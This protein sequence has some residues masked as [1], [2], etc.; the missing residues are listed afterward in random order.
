MGPEADAESPRQVRRLIVVVAVGIFVTGF[1]WPGIIGRLPFTLLLKNQ[2]GLGADKVAAFWAVATFAWYCK[3]LVGLVCDAYPF[4]GTRR[5]GYMLWGA[6]LAS[7]CWLGFAFVPRRYVPFMALMTGLNLALVFV[8]TVVGG[9]QV[10]ASQRLGATGRFASMRSALEGTMYLLSGPI[11]GFLAVLA[12]GWTSLAGGLILFS[13]VPVVARL[14]PEA[15][16]ARAQAA[17]W[18]SAR[19][20]LA[21]IVRSRPMWGT[22]GLTFLYYLAPGFQTPLL[23]V[24]QDVLKLDPRMMGLLVALSGVGWMIGSAIYAALCRRL[25]LRTLLVAGIAINGLGTLLYLRYD[26]ALAAVVIETV[27]GV[28]YTLAALP[29]ADLIARATPKGSESFGF[30]LMMSIRNVA[31]FAISD[32]VGSKLY[33]QYHV[34]FPRLVWINTLST[35]AVLLFVP[36]LPR[37]ILAAREG[38]P[39]RPSGTEPNSQ[40]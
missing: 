9:L 21:A 40:A 6:L 14:Y 26:S 34:G 35:L 33:A 15:R 17:V 27:F 28:L 10:E 4:A 3:P 23:Y 20:Q 18:S 16:G 12:F 19:S 5:R 29:L 31:I 39:A 38:E 7:V 36:F 1:G 2:L 13:F 32:V 24:Q 22:A 37:A 30:G 8:S 25:P 11:S